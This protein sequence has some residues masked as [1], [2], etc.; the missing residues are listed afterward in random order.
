MAD[1]LTAVCQ[2]LYGNIQHTFM[3]VKKKSEIIRINVTQM[4]YFLGEENKWSHQVNSPFSIYDVIS[5]GCFKYCEILFAIGCFY[6]KLTFL[7][8]T[9]ISGYY[10]N[11]DSIMITNETFGSGKILDLPHDTL[12]FV[13]F[14]FETH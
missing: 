12:V 2:Q 10:I 14:S 13:Y 4:K 11:V 6:P 1:H 7:K 8:I 9:F 3:P 5:A